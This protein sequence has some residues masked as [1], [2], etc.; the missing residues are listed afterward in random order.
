[1]VYMGS[2]GARGCLRGARG[3]GGALVGGPAG[4]GRGASCLLVIFLQSANGGR[5]ILL[6]VML[7]IEQI[8]EN[9]CVSQIAKSFVTLITGEVKE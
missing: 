3:A 6:F 8:I 7:S 9:Y 1:V 4:A 2:I 5:I